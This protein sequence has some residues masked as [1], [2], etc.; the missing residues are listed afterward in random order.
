M[1]LVIVR[2]LDVSMF[3]TDTNVRQAGHFWLLRDERRHGRL[4]LGQ[5]GGVED[6]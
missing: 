2:P 5:Q 1:I 4:L 6:G 3:V